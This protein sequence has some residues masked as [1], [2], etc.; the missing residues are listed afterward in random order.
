MIPLWYRPHLPLLLPVRR[1][2]P[3]AR[4]SGRCNV[5]FLR[6]DADCVRGLGPN[7]IRLS[8]RPVPFALNVVAKLLAFAERVLSLFLPQ[9]KGASGVQVGKDAQRHISSRAVSVE[10]RVERETG[11]DVGG[12]EKC[13]EMVTKSAQISGL[14][15]P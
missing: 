1:V 12:H 9:R 2:T 13:P 7:R 6:A 15:Q 10:T 14:S 3:V 5:L 8:L 4:E 11:L